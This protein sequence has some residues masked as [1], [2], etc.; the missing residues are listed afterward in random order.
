MICNGHSHCSRLLYIRAR[1]ADV[2]HNLNVSNPVPKVYTIYGTT[3]DR[4]IGGQ[5]S[6]RIAPPSLPSHHSGPATRDFQSSIWLKR[7]SAGVIW[8][9]RASFTNNS[10]PLPWSSIRWSPPM[11]WIMRANATM[12][13]KVSS[14]IWKYPFTLSLSR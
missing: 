3:E 7:S 14:A 10:C 2:H 13:W 6:V 9:C 4:V 8:M 11:Q 1:N 12:C 5:R